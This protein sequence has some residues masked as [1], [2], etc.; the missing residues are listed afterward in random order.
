MTKVDGKNKGMANGGAKKPRGAD[1]LKL[2][3]WSDEDAC[4]I[5]SAPPIITDACHGD[6]P[7]EVYRELCV[8]VEEW[9]DIME[10]D[11]VPVPAPN[12]QKR[13]SGKFNLRT[14]RELHKALEIRATQQGESLNT[15]CVN[16]LK[17]AVERGSESRRGRNGK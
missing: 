1:Y 7:A 13:Y 11:G 16:S 6:E 9:L 8:I 10:A 3:E 14:G 4:F 12:L 17:A 15:F 2:V 5:G